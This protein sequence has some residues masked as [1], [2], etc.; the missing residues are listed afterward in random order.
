M[1]KKYKLIFISCIKICFLTL[2][3][4]WTIK[5][6]GQEKSSNEIPTIPFCELLRNPKD[7]DQKTV[8]VMAIYR[9]GFEVSDLFCLDCEDEKLIRLESGENFTS[10]TERKILKKIKWTERGKTVKV[11]AIGKFYGT[12]AY[13][14]RKKF[15]V[16]YFESAEVILNSSPSVLPDNVK[17]KANCSN[18]KSE[19]Q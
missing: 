6:N 18:E 1:D 11:V 10:R 8:R 7:Y 9:Y 15:V 3:F 14:Y 17:N 4:T 19:K 16:D 2:I 5:V 13:Q 12:G